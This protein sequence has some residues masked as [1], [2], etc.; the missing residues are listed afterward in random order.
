MSAS[1]AVRASPEASVRDAA[2]RAMRVSTASGSPAFCDVATGGGVG[3]ASTVMTSRAALCRQVQGLLA[4]AAV[5]DQI[6]APFAVEQQVETQ[7]ATGGARV[8]PERGEV[9]SLVVELHRVAD[10]CHVL[11]QIV[12]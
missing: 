1:S 10:L 12:A 8:E 3:C 4:A 5:A 7:A 6:R 11:A 2:A 9:V